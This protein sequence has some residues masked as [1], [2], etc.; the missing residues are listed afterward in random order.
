MKSSKI[1]LT[2]VELLIT[3][4]IMSVIIAAVMT[5]MAI[6]MKSYEKIQDQYECNANLAIVAKHIRK[7]VM[8]SACVKIIN[9]G[10]GLELYDA[11]GA[12]VI[13]TYSLTDKTLNYNGA[14][15]ANNI[16]LT[17]SKHAV[18]DGKV[19]AVKVEFIE[20]FSDSFY[21]C[22]RRTY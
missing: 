8:D 20:P 1:G 11:P 22:C 21:I 7:R 13:G 17:F 3:V 5:T 6:G 14:D 10:T 16:V 9:S 12:A 18:I 2:L 19:Q 15:I 4:A